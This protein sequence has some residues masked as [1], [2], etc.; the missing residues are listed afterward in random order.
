[1]EKAIAD[2]RSPGI[3]AKLVQHLAESYERCAAMVNAVDESVPSK[4][5]KVRYH[6]FV[7][8]SIYVVFHLTMSLHAFKLGR[9]FI[10]IS[11]SKY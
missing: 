7:F 5:R 10:S 2:K 8:N 3:T 4:F 1:M 9:F 6:L 11:L